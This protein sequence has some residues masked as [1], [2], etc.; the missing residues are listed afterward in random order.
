[1]I[2]KLI[3]LLRVYSYLHVQAQIM[4]IIRLKSDPSLLNMSV[5]E[6]TK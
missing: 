3:V 4:I 2:F 5:L 6:K 1:M